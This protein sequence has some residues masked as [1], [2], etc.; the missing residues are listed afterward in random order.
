[1]CLADYCDVLRCDVLET[2]RDEGAEMTTAVDV[3]TSAAVERARSRERSEWEDDY[4]RA[5]TPSC[6]HISCHCVADGS[7]EVGDILNDEM[8]PNQ[9]N[10]QTCSGEESCREKNDSVGK[11]S[12]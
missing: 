10:L 3:W 1:M 2:R 12:R 7:L 6:F 4:H 9:K 8:M 11:L 5:M